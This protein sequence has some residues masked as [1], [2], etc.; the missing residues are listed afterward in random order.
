PSGFARVLPKYPPRP[1]GRRFPETR[2]G[3]LGGGFANPCP[4]QPGGRSRF[5]KG[6][7]GAS[8]TALHP[9]D[10]CIPSSSAATSAA[11]TSAPGTG[12]VTA[13]TPNGRVSQP[14]ERVQPV[15]PGLD[16]PLSPRELDPPLRDPD[17]GLGA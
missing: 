6:V 3:Y 11:R 7:R 1:G 14:M 2:V 4:C 8:P 10:E 16:L 5:S 9:T 13:G 17:A 15:E 12:H